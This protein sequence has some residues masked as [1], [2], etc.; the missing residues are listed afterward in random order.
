MKNGKAIK[1][2]SLLFGI[3]LFAA[4]IC[5]SCARSAPSNKNVRV[6]VTDGLS[7]YV[8]GV[9]VVLPGQ[10]ER[11]LLLDSIDLESRVPT[12]QYKYA[13][14]GHKQKTVEMDFDHDGKRATFRF[15]VVKVGNRTIPI[16]KALAHDPDGTN[17][18]LTR[19]G[20]S[21]RFVMS[22]APSLYLV[23]FD[24]GEISKFLPD[25]SGD[26]TIDMMPEWA[27]GPLYVSPDGSMLVYET[28][29]FSY[30]ESNH[31]NN[32][33]MLYD[34]DTGTERPLTFD[35]AVYYDGPLVWNGK[36]SIF[37]YNCGW[38]II[39]LSLT[40]S[41]K[42]DVIQNDVGG[43]ACSA[44][45]YPYIVFWTDDGYQLLNCETRISTRLE[46]IPPD[47]DDHDGA[48]FNH[49]SEKPLILF[50]KCVS[51]SAILY[52]LEPASC[53]L[54]EIFSIDGPFLPAACSWKDDRTVA[55]SGTGPEGEKTYLIDI[56]NVF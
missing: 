11:Q 18:V 4:L 48:V 12:Y 16:H 29:R 30:S 37:F 32:A 1:E 6:R 52:L 45:V 42:A 55:V 25:E 54:V 9:K 27:Y 41:G 5:A 36:E 22:F 31:H 3:V 10:K 46:D 8:E 34:F 33:M 17:R 28:G 38:Q 26:V 15:T 47:R 20:D 35:H 2:K 13:T 51:D 39:E 53:R 7:C 44:A 43:A 40:G 56:R 50:Y 23:D 19:L 24:T 14:P 21:N 49:D